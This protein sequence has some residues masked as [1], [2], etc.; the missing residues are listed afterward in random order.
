MRTHLGI[1]GEDDGRVGD[2]VQRGGDDAVGDGEDG[3]DGEVLVVG[4]GDGR[5]VVAAAGDVHAG[6]VGVL[7][8]LRDDDD[9]LVRPHGAADLGRVE[10]GLGRDVQDIAT[11]RTQNTA[12]HNHD[13]TRHAQRWVSEPREAGGRGAAAA[14]GVPTYVH[15]PLVPL[16]IRAPVSK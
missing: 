12:R 8:V 7:E 16:V 14:V 5:V 10:P 13:A 9:E 15:S 3:G 4:G 11:G 1:G 2:L 6:G